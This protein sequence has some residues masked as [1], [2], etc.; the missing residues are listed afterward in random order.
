MATVAA[1]LLG[2]VRD[3]GVEQV[4]RPGDGVNGILGAF[5]RADNSPAFIQSALRR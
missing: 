1:F 5:G 4:L 2:R 3:W